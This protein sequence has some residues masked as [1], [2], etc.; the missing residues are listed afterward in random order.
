MNETGFGVNMSGEM[1]NRSIGELQIDRNHEK[2]SRGEQSAVSLIRDG[3]PKTSYGNR[4]SHLPNH[5]PAKCRL[6]HRWGSYESP[7]LNQTVVIVRCTKRERRKYMMTRREA[8]KTVALTAGALALGPSLVRAENPDAIPGDSAYPF[9]VPD[10]GY[11][12]DALEPYIDAQTMQIHHDKHY[13]AYVENLNKAM[14]QAP[15]RIQ[16]MSVEELLVNLESIPEKIRPAVRNS[17]GGQYNHSL[18]WKLLKKNEGGKASGELAKAIDL[19]FGSY[20]NF[21]AKFTEVATKL[22]GSGWAWL[23]VDGNSLEITTTPN[24]DSTLSKS[25]RKQVPIV[26]IDLWEHA[27]YLKY[28]NRRPEYIKAF[29][30]VI[31]WDYASQRFVE[32]T[33]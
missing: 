9:K 3:K 10:L 33:T 30:N 14:V 17:A 32:A 13:G 11:A 27:Y 22:F 5:K 19:T 8:I 24:Q 16:K 29:W 15:E 20:S 28:Q 21:Q 23:V 18:F 2:N 4:R 1:S 7:R 12:Y 26:G 6:R 25:Q 31:N